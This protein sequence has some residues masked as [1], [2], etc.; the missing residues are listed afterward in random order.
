MLGASLA[1]LVADAGEDSD[2]LVLIAEALK[3]LSPREQDF[4]RNFAVTY[5]LHSKAGQEQ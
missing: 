4:V 2:T 1:A 3:G 5:C